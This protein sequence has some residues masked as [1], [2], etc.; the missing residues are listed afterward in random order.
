MSRPLAGYIGYDAE[1]AT[2]AA[3]GIWTLREAELYQRKAQWP[4]PPLNPSTITGLQLWLD[5][6]DASTLYDATTGGSLVAAD[7]GVAR[8][9]DKSGND[10]HATQGT[11]GARPLRKTSIQG[12]LDVM[13]FDGTDDLLAVSGSASSMKFLHSS[14]STVFLALK[15]GTVSDPNTFYSILGTNALSSANVGFCIF[16]DD[17]ATFS[18]FDR[19]RIFFSEGTAGEFPIN[20]V[21]TDNEF[22]PNTFSLFSAVIQPSNGTAADRAFR[23]RN[24]SLLSQSNTSTATPSTADA[25][26]DVQIGANGGSGALLNGDICEILIYDTAL[27]DTDREAVENYLLAKWGIS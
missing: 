10:R 14:N 7:G 15:V 6:S 23:Y 16:F 8:W 4:L 27:S 20:D 18:L 26:N 3:P 9:E 17:R 24:G 19:F 13:R 21:G 2:D 1:P 25:T 5:A 22:P 12:G 11:A